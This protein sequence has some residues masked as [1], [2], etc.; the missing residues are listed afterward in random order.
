MKKTYAS[1]CLLLFLMISIILSLLG[2]AADGADTDDQTSA[3][4]TEEIQLGETID[5]KEY[6]VVYMLPADDSLDRSTGQSATVIKN[7]IKDNTGIFPDKVMI[8]ADAEMTDEY[9]EVKEI[10]VGKTNRPESEEAMKLIEGNE[11]FVV[12]VIGSKIVVNGTSVEYIRYAADYFI[13]LYLKNM[14]E[15]VIFMASD[16]KYVGMK[17][18][19]PVKPDE[20]SPGH[21]Y[22]GKS[23]KLFIIDPPDERRHLMQGNCYVDGYYYVVFYEADGS[24]AMNVILK[25]DK[26]GNCVAQSEPLFI[27]HSNCVTYVPKW[28]ALLVSHCQGVD[29]EAFSRY[30][31]VDIETLQVIKTDVLSQP[32]FA[33]GYSPDRDMFASGEFSGEAIDIWNGDLKLSDRYQVLK[34]DSLSQGMWCDENSIWFVRSTTENHCAEIRI[35]DWDG[36]LLHTIDLD[37]EVEPEDITVTDGRI[38]VCSNNETWTGGCAYEIFLYEIF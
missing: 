13:D 8:K 12:A 20:L 5:L 24:D 7:T 33:M 11:G 10:L 37:L 32:F 38:L 16:E 1:R 29:K 22:I 23:Q 31:L 19:T 27:E 17:H 36:E 26:D 9:K 35:Y 30:S 34:P 2:C 3:E 25:I 21:Q 18:E 15:G 28:N 4:S 6:K 14:K